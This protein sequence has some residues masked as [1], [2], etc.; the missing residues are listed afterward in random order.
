MWASA[1]ILLIYNFS[2]HLNAYIDRSE[3]LSVQ[4]SVYGLNLYQTH[5]LPIPPP[6]VHLLSIFY[7][8]F[9]SS[10]TDVTN[11]NQWIVEHQYIPKEPEKIDN[12]DQWLTLRVP[13]YCLFSRWKGEIQKQMEI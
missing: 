7:F 4:R 10:G 13:V 12:D 1:V 5:H 3:K 9:K 2:I 11:T 8:E 6:T